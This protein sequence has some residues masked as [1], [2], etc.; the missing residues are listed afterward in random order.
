MLDHESAKVA[1]IPQYFKDSNMPVPKDDFPRNIIIPQCH[2]RYIIGMD[3]WT[4]L[5]PQFFWSEHDSNWWR[6]WFWSLD[7][8]TK[9]HH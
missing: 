9:A 5:M 3:F 6:K 2:V 4:N 1:I 8:H 7:P